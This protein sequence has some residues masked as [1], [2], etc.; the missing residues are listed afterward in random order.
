MRQTEN[1]FAEPNHLAAIRDHMPGHQVEQRGLASTVRPNE[2]G[3]D[4]GAQRKRNVVHGL[5]PAKG[6]GDSG[7][8]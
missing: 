5:Q 4:A 2:R 3:D 1:G 7:R 8:L 6:L